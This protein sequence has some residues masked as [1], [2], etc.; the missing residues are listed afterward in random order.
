MSKQTN[1]PGKK[2]APARVTKARPTTKSAAA[3]KAT[4]PEA[5]LKPNSLSA[6]EAAAKVLSNAAQPMG[7]RQMITAMGAQGLW[8]SPN[9]KTPAATLA[10]A[11]L[12]EIKLK[13]RESRFKKVGRGL[14]AFA[15]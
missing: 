5:P 9:G 7:C 8:V 12:R 1:K 4:P 15:G 3:P 14:F 10:A 13:G 2:R 11:M 6:L